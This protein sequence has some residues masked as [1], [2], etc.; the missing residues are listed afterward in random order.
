MHEKTALS[1]TIVVVC[2]V[3][4]INKMGESMNGNR[5]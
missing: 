5:R 4:K 1:T 3:E 2:Y